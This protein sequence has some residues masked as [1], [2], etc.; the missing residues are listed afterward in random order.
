MTMF[1]RKQSEGLMERTM[2]EIAAMELPD[3]AVLEYDGCGSH[4]ARFVWQEEMTPEEEQ[5]ERER[6]AAAERRL[7]E[8]ERE[9]RKA[10]F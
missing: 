1:K 6:R 10:G 5:A 8:E 7:A 4:E 9:D 3:D 2:A